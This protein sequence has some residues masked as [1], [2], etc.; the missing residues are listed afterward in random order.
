MEII[1][2]QLLF[3][4]CQ[5]MSYDGERDRGMECLI[6]LWTFPQKA[7]KQYQKLKRSELKTVY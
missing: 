3:D 4:I 1:R 5:Y 6:G 2:C 7:G